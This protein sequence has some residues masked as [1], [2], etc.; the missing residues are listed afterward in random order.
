MTSL[1][2]NGMA[3]LALLGTAILASHAAGRTVD[4]R[5]LPVDPALTAENWTTGV[6]DSEA[7]PA[8]WPR[9]IMMR[10]LGLARHV[11]PY[12]GLMQHSGWLNFRNAT[13]HVIF[14]ENGAFYLIEDSATVTAVAEAASG[15]GSRYPLDAALHK[16]V[17]RQAELRKAQS[18][19]NADIAVSTPADSA[20]LSERKNALQQ[21]EVALDG[22]VAQARADL[23]A[24]YAALGHDPHSPPE[25]AAQYDRIRALITGA[26]RAGL[27]KPASAPMEPGEPEMVSP[28]P[29]SVVAVTGNLAIEPGPGS[30]SDLIR[31]WRLRARVQSDYV[32]VQHHWGAYYCVTDPAT[33]AAVTAL[34]DTPNPGL[35]IG[36]IIADAID[37]GLAKRIEP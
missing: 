28:G 4:G 23:E 22:K 25:R 9:D 2:A 13:D 1:S 19:L 15:I 10:S 3:M 35:A 7:L 34:A 24:T 31:A 32:W 29:D 12:S 26:M 11:G 20:A 5:T 16:L 18:N 33:V 37:N 21:E 30:D 8:D 6:I 27:A 14:Q 36:R 17:V